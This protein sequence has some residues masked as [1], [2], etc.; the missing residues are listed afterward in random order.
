[1]WLV[2]IWVQFE[3]NWT[4]CRGRFLESQYPG[5]SR[6]L[7][8]C[9]LKIPWTQFFEVI[10]IRRK[11]RTNV[12]YCTAITDYTNFFEEMGCDSLDHL[13]DMVSSEFWSSKY[14]ST[15]NKVIVPDCVD[16]PNNDGPLLYRSQQVLLQLPLSPWFQFRNRTHAVPMEPM[17]PSGGML[18][19]SGMSVVSKILTVTG[20]D[21]SGMLDTIE[22]DPGPLKTGLPNLGEVSPNFSGSFDQVRILGHVGQQDK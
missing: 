21:L 14:L 10:C 8:D 22:M 19:S 7:L 20:A 5:Y 9:Y 1:M 13:L 18:D 6:D 4:Q 16:Q 15:W 11:N 3:S 17:D 12:R 2:Q